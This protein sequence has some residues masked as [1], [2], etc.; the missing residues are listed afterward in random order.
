LFPR[1]PIYVRVVGT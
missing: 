1:G